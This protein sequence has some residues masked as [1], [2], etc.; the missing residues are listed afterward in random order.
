M[1]IIRGHESLPDGYKMHRWNGP[2]E[3]PMVI[4]VFSAP[5]YCDVYGNK[6]AVIKFENNTLNIQQYN[7]A[8]HPYHLQ[9]FM[10]V[11]TWSIP[12]VCSKI[13]EMMIS[14]CKKGVADELEEPKKESVPL[15]MPKSIFFD[16][17]TNIK[18]SE[19]LRNKVKAMSRMMKMYRILQYF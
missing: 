11:F 12:Y 9:N 6:G 7:C 16:I 3:F 15:D 8:K 14:I 17:S 10:D 19:I 1:A 2:S 13:I 5:N 4:T 18:E